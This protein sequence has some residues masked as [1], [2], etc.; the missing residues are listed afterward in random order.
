MTIRNNES[1][2]KLL[3]WAKDGR[4]SASNAQKKCMPDDIRT[5]YR[6]AGRQAAFEELIGLIETDSVDSL[7]LK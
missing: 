4:D 6:A 1:F 5:I 3:K 7:P 2:A